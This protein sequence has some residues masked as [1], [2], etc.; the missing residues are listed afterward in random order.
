[1]IDVWFKTGDLGASARFYAMVWE[2]STT[3]RLFLYDKYDK[4]VVAFDA[5]VWQ[6]VCQVTSEVTSQD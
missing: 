4:M 3:G 1:M 2:I 6:Y 5:G